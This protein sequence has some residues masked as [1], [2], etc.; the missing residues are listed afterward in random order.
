MTNRLRTHLRTASWLFAFAG[1]FIASSLFAQPA[2]ITF[3][4]TGANPARVN[5]PGKCTASLADVKINNHV[6]AQSSIGRTIVQSYFD[7]TATGFGIN[8]Q[9]P[10]GC[11]FTIHW[12]AADDA[13]NT[14]SYTFNFVVVEDTVPVVTRLARDSI[15]YCNYPDGISNA[16]GHWIKTGGGAIA[17]DNCGYVTFK[18]QID[19]AGPLVDSAGIVAAFR[20]RSQQCEF[21]TVRTGCCTKVRG[22]LQVNFFAVDLSG[23]FAFAGGSFFVA[24]D[25]L[26][27]RLVGTPI[28][29]LNCN[30]ANNDANIAGWVH[31]F[32]GTSLRDDCSVASVLGYTWTTSTGQT[33]SGNV[34]S[35]PYPTFAGSNCDWWTDVTYQFA[36][37]CGNMGTQTLRLSV[38]DITPP[39]L[40]G[41]VPTTTLYCPTPFPTAFSGSVADNCTAAPTLNA[42]VYHFSDTICGGNYRLR[43]TWSA[44]D[45]C[46]NTGTTTQDFL[47]RDTLTPVFTRV[48]AGISVACDSVSSLVLPVMGV[49]VQ[50]TDRCGVLRDIALTNTVSTRDP[51]PAVC[52]HYNYTLTRF[53]TATD[54]CGNSATSS[55]LVTVRDTRPPLIRGFADTTII[56]NRPLPGTPIPLVRDG[57]QS[58]LTPTIL[59]E[60]ILP[61]TC[62]DNYT[63]VVTWTAADAC[64]N[65]ASFTQQIQVRDTIR[66]ALVGIPANAT[67]TCGAIPQAPAITGL[68]A[69]GID[70]CDATLDVNL[71][72]AETRDPNIANCAHWTNYIIRRTWT[73]VDN[74]NNSRSYTQVITVQDNAPPVITL[75][76][77]FS[78]PA[79]PGQCS[80]SI[81]IPAPLSVT[82]DCTTGGEATVVR[83]SAFFRAPVGQNPNE[84]AVDT[85]VINLVVAATPPNRAAL[86]DGTLSINLLSADA[87]AAGENFVI[88]GENGVRLGE[89]SPTDRQCGDGVTTVPVTAAQ[90]QNW[91]TDGRLTIR[92][93]PNGTGGTAV[94][95][96]CSNGRARATLNFNA[97]SQR[98]PITVT[99]SLDGGPSQVF[100][101]TA[102]VS[103]NAGDHIIRYTATDCAGNVSTASVTLRIDDVE[104]PIV[105]AVAPITTFTEQNTC[106]RNVILPFPG[107]TENCGTAAQINVTTPAQ[108]V[109][110]EANP[111]AG[112]VPRPVEIT[113]NGLIP[114]ALTN[115][116]LRI[117]HIGDNA[118]LGEFF[119]IFDENNVRIASTTNGQ[120][121][122]QCRRAHETVI[123]VTVLQ[124]NAWAADGV[125]RFRL[126]PNTNAASFTDF[127][128][129]CGPLN[130]QSLD[131]TSSI[132]ANLSYS[133]AVVNYEVLRGNT[134]VRTGNVIGTTTGVDL[135]VGQYTVNYRVTDAAGNTGTTSFSVIVRDTIRPVAVCVTSRTLFTNPSGLVNITITA[136]DLNNVSTD[137]CTSPNN[138]ALTAS[139]TVF[140]CN[141]AGQTIPVTLTVRDSSGNTSSCQVPIRIETS[142]VQPT[143]SPNICEG[144]SIQ[145]F[146]NP[147]IAPGSPTYTYAWTGPSGFMSNTENPVINNVKPADRGSYRVVIT[148]PTGC[149][150]SGVVQ[151]DLVSRPDEPS[152]TVTS[153]SICIGENITLRSGAYAGA[154][155]V[156]NWYSGTPANPR[157]L[158]TTTVRDFNITNPPPGTY[159]YYVQVSITSCSSLPSQV[160]TVVVNSL[161]TA[162]VDESRI[163]LCEGQSLRLGTQ[164]QGTGVTYS[165]SGPDQFGSTAQ[166]PPLRNNITKGQEG[167]YSLVVTQNGCVSAPAVVTVTVR[168]KP[169]PPEVVLDN[170][171]V[172]VGATVNFVA[173]TPPGSSISDYIW[174]SPRLDSTVTRVNALAVN[175][176]A[177]NQAGV[178]RVSVIQ[179]GCA[180]DQRSVLLQV[181]DFPQLQARANTPLC[182]VDT[183]RLNASANQTDIRYSWTGPSGFSSFEQ[184]PRRSPAESGVYTLAGS[185]S[186]GCRSTAT[187]TVVAAPRPV[188]TSITDNA[189]TCSDGTPSVTLQ[190]VHGSLNGVR[191]YLWSG[192]LGFN[193]TAVNPVVTNFSA[194]KNGTYIL[195]IVDTI[196]CRSLP[197]SKTVRV[198]DLPATPVLQALTPICAGQ[199]TTVIVANR[200]NYSFG[201]FSF[202]WQT[203]LGRRDTTQPVF[204]IPAGSMAAAGNY[205]VV[206]RSANCASLPSAA[207]NLTVFPIPTPPVVTANTPLCEGDTL[208][209]QTPFI[210]GAQ[211]EWTGPF[212]FTASTFNPF[213]AQV[214][215]VHVG[216]YQANITVNGCKSPFGPVQDI[217]VRARPPKPEIRQPVAAVCLQQRDTVRLEVTSLSQTNGATYTWF[218]RLLGVQLGQTNVPAFTFTDLV[219]LPAGVNK[220][221][222][223]ARSNGCNS[224]ESDPVD[225]NVDVIPSDRALAGDDFNAC[226]RQTNVLRASP[227]AVATGVWRQIDGPPTTIASPSSFR[228]DVIGIVAGQAYFYEW[229]LS[230]GACENYMR[231]TI[232]LTGV[233]FERANAVE[234]VDTCYARGINLRATQGATTTGFWSQPIE[235]QG[236]GVTIGDP[237]NPNS[238][239]TGLATGKNIFIWTLRDIGC[240]VSTDTMSVFNFDSRAFAGIDFSFCDRTGCA[241]LTAS[242]L[243]SF[244]QGRWTSPDPALQF[245][246]PGSASTS[247]CSLKVGENI[248]IWTINEGLCGLLSRD[249]VIVNYELTPSA[250]LDQIPVSFAETKQ[251]NVLL[252]DLLPPKFSEEK[253]SDPLHGRLIR[254]GTGSYTYRPDLSYDGPDEFLYEICNLNC[255]AS[256]QSQ[257]DQGRVVFNVAKPTDCDIPTVITPNGDGV[258]DIFF[259]PCLGDGPSAIDN[260]VIIFNQWG[261]EVFY[262]RPYK[263]DWGGTFG[264]KPLPAGTYFFIVDYR[265][266]RLGVKKGFLMIQY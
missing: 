156:Y 259:V 83:D 90:L 147:P 266:E 247:V 224:Q 207:V 184:N 140:T 168:E 71:S 213:I 158:G 250:R 188:V 130:A 14:A 176:I 153:N 198:E 75:P 33:G 260:E 244:E 126:V 136:A 151:V 209:L 223:V 41:I 120:D 232:R 167:D 131:G 68:I 138:L 60:R 79:Q 160:R 117:R 255:R 225:F 62:P 17:T 105:T 95:A 69:A 154:N 78:R 204:F 124:I 67:V 157:L 53:Y 121:T 104:P 52:G 180:S 48:P 201:T 115:G 27:P 16:L 170:D 35:G 134:M 152:L 195:E 100:P 50:A 187:V 61:G 94:N 222:V 109:S 42:P 25:T 15:A 3:V 236:F 162:T 200:E 123:P 174:R 141:L 102:P 171:K 246:S 108:L 5:I 150:A 45:A 107:I 221:T 248:L 12:F 97:A 24:R 237:N 165:W 113:V 32:G 220:F 30:T 181:Q 263:N 197:F 226:D 240:G 161:P 164:I 92:L 20:E 227:P 182:Q 93:V 111:N 76:Q 148:G 215:D 186:F 253:V 98:L 2:D 44:T 199:S 256:K 70:N 106:S 81:V 28:A 233:S 65:S 145:L 13:G 19:A 125:A 230:N 72:V 251:I 143:Y 210:A 202:Q 112:L 43:I 185:T 37:D 205:S 22:L 80:A 212:G 191:N 116:V 18:A 88:F 103:L 203:P 219:T 73:A 216:S 192:P 241:P 31:S 96:I 47:V 23:N 87:E 231:D 239:V 137:N 155:V 146:A 46:G 211:Y 6:V 214:R 128:S 7:S 245:A 57:C 217:T 132:S 234:R 55:Q 89:T 166:F 257:C 149:T 58:N 74:C 142:V 175:N 206:A 208:K 119:D 235:Q 49:D 86:A 144:N 84:V 110:F 254:N 91:L 196:G 262:A 26:P 114:N 243:G 85:V 229:T 77:V 101:A 242:N 261:N 189:P 127:I 179:R 177:L 163:S 118:Q 54:A 29:Q 190:G 36:D 63:R 129:P 21:K 169:A 159:Q 135:N 193:S 172:C 252:N 265:D 264:N 82:D 59:N 56:C 173:S 8:H 64:G 238:P 139:Q 39:V 178:W 11:P 228:S 1:L 99:Y 133:Y 218:N 40:S 38:R 51:N 34:T 10:L 122:S 4:Y 258:N 66:P 194:T 9:I 249:T 183:L